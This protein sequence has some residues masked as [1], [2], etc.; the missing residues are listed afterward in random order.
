[1]RQGG[2]QFAA[3]FA[4]AI[5]VCA[6]ALI[7]PVFSASAQDV[8]ADESAHEE[9]M[10]RI[11][12]DQPVTF[13]LFQN[14]SIMESSLETPAWNERF[15]LAPDAAQ[16]EFSSPFS[17]ALQFD[18]GQNWGVAFDFER[19]QVDTFDLESIR[20]GA[21]FDFTPRFRLGG[22]FSYASDFST[23]IRLDERTDDESGIKFSSAFRF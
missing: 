6:P 14:Q 9:G 12:F 22:E 16:A 7:A 15:T 23:D 5:A 19:D 17:Y 11:A 2:R 10:S 4:L 13:D 3:A 1:M 20:A 18:A 8:K 21:F